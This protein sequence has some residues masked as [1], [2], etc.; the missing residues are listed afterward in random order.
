MS[1]TTSFITLPGCPLQGNNPLPYLKVVPENIA[2]LEDG[3]LTS[4]EQKLF[5]YQCSRRVLPYLM[6]DRYTR[7][8]ESMNIKTILLENENLKATF[9]PEYGGRLYSLYSKVLKRELLYTN[10]VMQPA[11]LS[12][13]NAWFSGGIEWNIGRIGHTFTTCDSVFFAVVKGEEEDF[14][15]MYEFE[16]QRRL[17]W[18]IDF[19]LPAGADQLSA[20]VRITNDDNEDKPMYWWT[21][22]AVPI[23]PKTRVFSQS[24]EIFYIKP[25]GISAG[26]S[27][28]GHSKLPFVPT[29]AAEDVTYPDQI[30]F[31]SEYFFQNEESDKTAW[32]AVS[33]E[34]N[35]LFYE[36]SSAPL[37]YRKMFTWGNSR[38]G[39][40]WCNFLS[41]PGKGDYLE[42]QAGLAPSQLHGYII[43]ANHSL[44]FT[45]IFGGLQDEALSADAN[46]EY[47]RSKFKIKARITSILP[48]E[49]VLLLEKQYALDTNRSPDLLLSYGS[50]FGAL[51]VLRRQVSSE[52][53]IPHGLLFPED[54]LG[55]EQLI[56]KQLLTGEPFSVLPKGDCPLSF[57]TDLKWEPYFV[58]VIS[59]ADDAYNWYFFF[60]YGIFLYENDYFEKAILMWQHSLAVKENP[61]SARM[62]AEMLLK[63]ED[64][65]L[66]I[67]RFQLKDIA[68]Q[69]T[70]PHRERIIAYY[71]KLAYNL[72]GKELSPAFGEE[73]I[74]Q[75]IQLKDYESAWQLY[76]DESA[77]AIPT[78]RFLISAAKAGMEL[79]DN[80]VV[81][82]LF[83]NPPSIIREGERSLTNLWFEYTARQAAIKMQLPYTEELYQEIVST[84]LPPK[85]LD[86]RMYPS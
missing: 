84:T 37:T 15:R 17:F 7:T 41:D 6:Q 53:S 34:D 46:D 11:N 44:C 82:Y 28:Y 64:L 40:Q 59:K 21:N 71:L 12:I 51:E 5:G 69:D 14:L 48:E 77:T 19:H 81:T 85:D 1:I 67:P 35:Y 54:S 43:P 74:A 13:R 25:E 27:I 47:E 33:Y 4:R 36:C 79:G 75:Y 10:P 30:D 22:A 65:T 20:C 2:P 16:R 78:D 38:G 57:M 73:L 50:G 18:Q 31:G 61:W 70:A 39:R 24:S 60:H 23:T 58:S 9:L 42:V 68:S 3:T 86:Y 63:N 80:R 66:L 32:E 83:E 49:K 52:P 8:R 26:K 62:L 45:Q 55:K 29:I 56:W 76:L 72:G